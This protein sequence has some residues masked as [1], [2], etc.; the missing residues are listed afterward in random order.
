MTVAGRYELPPLAGRKYVAFTDP[1][2]GSQDAFTL[3]IAHL[4]GKT[5][6][7]D[8]V[9]EV[10]PPF[11]PDGVVQGFAELLKSYGVTAVSG[12]HYAGEWPR[13]RFRVHGIGYQPAEKPKSGIYRALLPAVTSGR[14]ELLD[15]PRLRV[16]LLGLERR[17]ARSGND[18]I[19]HP[20]GAHDD[21]ANAV[22]GALTRALGA[23]AVRW[24]LGPIEERTAA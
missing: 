13:E 22:A 14:V 7:L 16:Q 8:A 5:A 12:D 21:V 11:S 9:R 4:E 1:S 23:R 10:R 3:A 24:W 17:V 20:P 19:D 6:V 15:H 18:S 2:G